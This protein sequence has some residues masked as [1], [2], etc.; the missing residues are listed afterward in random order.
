MKFTNKK[1]LKVL[2]IFL[3]F[4]VII[5]TFI[6]LLFTF[7]QASAKTKSSA[8]FVKK[9][10]S[11]SVNKEVQYQ[12]KNLKKTEYAHFFI[13]DTTLASIQKETGL[14]IPKKAGKLT[15]TAKI[16]NKKQQL[17]KTLKDNISIKKNKSILPNAS[18]QLKETI[19]PWNFTLI[20]SCN[21][22]LLK[23]EISSDT[24]TILPKGKTTPKLTASFTSLSSDGKEVIYTLTSSSQKKL[25][26]GDCSMDGNYILKSTCFSKKLSLTYEERLTENTLSGFILKENGNPIKNA[27]LSLKRTGLSDKTCF[28][29]SNGYYQ[30][31]NISNPA[32]LTIEKE[33]YQTKNIINPVISSEGTTC[34]NIILR[35][36]KDTSATL[37]FLITDTKNNPISDAVITILKRKDTDTDNS[38]SSASSSNNITI[39]KEN[40]LFSS[41]T[42]STGTLL[43]TNSD[44]LTSAPCSNLNLHQNATLSY[45]AS[46]QLFSTNTSIL[47][48]SILNTVDNYTIYISKF[49]PDHVS[50]AYQTQRLDFSFSDLITNQANIHIKLNKCQHLTINNFTL[51]TTNSLIDIH[52]L[53]L[54]FY[55]PE[56]RKSFYQYT[57]SKEQFTQNK[58]NITLSSNLPLS[59]PDGTYYLSVEA[60]S[61]GNTTLE[62]SAIFPIIIQNS[63]LSLTNTN[64]ISLNPTR[65]ARILAYSDSIDNLLSDCSFQL[66]QK[67]DCY[68]FFINTFNIKTSTKKSNNNYTTAT[69][70]LSHLLPEQNYLL[71]PTDNRFSLK[72]TALFFTTENNTYLTKNEAE[73]STS[74]ITKIQCILTDNY[75]HSDIEKDF[76]SNTISIAYHTIHIISQDFIRSSKSYPNCVMALY[77]KDGSLLSLHLTLPATD[78]KTIYSSNKTNSII[79]IY[80]NKEILITN[81]DSYS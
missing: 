5:S 52:T 69:I 23:S 68:Y 81:Q 42:D 51:C 44:S 7:H 46:T 78:L 15:I 12:I 65:F 72:E 11:L 48:S 24:L 13:S 35:S 18:F 50:S 66:Y 3:I 79:D 22:I 19:N 73:Y 45:T 41:T 6:S 60:L 53:S 77:Q 56:H 76:S 70:L 20:L 74:P 30:F 2:T 21:R 55:H 57:I 64:S 39:D 37:K 71:L 43:L 10:Q 75:E 49:S 17:I 47:P 58:G 62:A 38:Y 27:L 31:K 61:E 67:C 16:Y 34:E 54:Y 36:S 4:T 9:Y 40:I 25:C 29:D 28:S 80:T 59:I 32:S 33:G 1:T 14:L 26:P 63:I 8:S